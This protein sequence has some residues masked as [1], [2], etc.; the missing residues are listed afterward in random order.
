MFEIQRA[1]PAA[2]LQRVKMQL[3]VLRSAM[4]HS[5]S[6]CVAGD[7]TGASVHVHVLL[8]HVLLL[9][10][11]HSSCCSCTAAVGHQAKPLIDDGLPGISKVMFSSGTSMVRPFGR[12]MQASPRPLKARVH[13]RRTMPGPQLLAGNAAMMVARNGRKISSFLC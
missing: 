1:V 2:V 6:C 4:V 12:V 9:H 10:V 5:S 11:H 3:Q 8:L 7:V 13:S